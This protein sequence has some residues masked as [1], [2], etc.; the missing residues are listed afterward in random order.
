MTEHEMDFEELEAMVDPA[1]LEALEGP[2]AKLTQE[3]DI[4]LFV[5]P[6]CSVCPHQVKAV[7]ALT[8]ASPLI[9]AEIVDVMSEPELAQQ[10]DVR[11]VPTTV[12]NDE[13]VL[14]GAKHPLQMAEILLA[15]EG[16]E[17]EKALLASL[18]ESGRIEDAADRLLYGPEPEAVLHAFLDLWSRSTLQDRMGLS[19]V[20][21]EVL[22]QDA[23]GLDGL[24][25]LLVAGLQDGSPLTQDPARKGD[26][27]DL[28]GKIGHPDA[29]PV[30][31]ALSRDPNPEVAEAAAD[32]L[33]NLEEPE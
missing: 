19:L 7:A 23:E 20:V 12:V 18:V 17:G 8:L 14:V 22:D 2:L 10:Y 4:L 29:R 27:A 24:V 30:L 33:E 16:P 25:P 9:A 6:G 15:R 28:L 26:T 31:E 11:A 32:A 21:E 13:L 1:I 5:A 3:V